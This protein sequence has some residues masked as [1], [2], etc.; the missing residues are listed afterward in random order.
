MGELY[1]TKTRAV[2][3]RQELKRR[4]A[5]VLGHAGYVTGT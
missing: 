3:P 2:L 1:Y 5:L 4:G